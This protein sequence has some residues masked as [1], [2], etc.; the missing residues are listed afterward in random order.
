MDL[1]QA[2]ERVARL[3]EELRR[4]NYLYYSKGEPEIS[5]AEYDRLLAELQELEQRFPR[6]RLPD[7]PTQTVGAPLQTSFTPVRHR[8]P[9]LSLESG[10]SEEAARDF[11]RRLDQA[12]FSQARL[13]AQPKIDGLSVELVYEQGLFHTGST[14]GDGVTGEDITPNLRTIKQIPQHLGPEAPEL[15]VVRG[16]VYMDRSGFDRL[17]RGLLEQGQDA[18]ANPRNAAAGSLRQLNPQVTA[19]RPLRFF[20]FE[21]VNADDLGYQA[22]GQALEALTDLGFPV[23]AEHVRFGQGFDFL[24]QVHADY[25]EVRDELAFEIDGVVFKIDSLEQRALWGVRSRNPR[26]AFAWKFPPREEVTTVREVIVQVGRTGKLTPVAL[27]MPVD[28]SGVTV[29]RATLHNF[30]QVAKLGVRPGDLVRVQRAGDVIP[31]VVS[32]EKEGEPRG[33]EVKPPL[34]CPVCGAG[35]VAADKVVQVTKAGVVKKQGANHLCPNSLGCPA[36]IKG[37]LFHYGSRTAMDIE[38]LGEKSVAQL[39]DKG[40][41]SDLPSLYRLQEKR[42]EMEKLDGWGRLSVDNLLGSIEAT[43]GKSLA[44]FLFALG[45]PGVGEATAREIAEH[46][47]SFEAVAAAGKDT[48]E[49]IPGVG[50][51]VA[52]NLIRFFN[53][54]QTRAVAQALATEVRPKAAVKIRDGE[55]LPL[56]GQTL[57]FTGGMNSL[58]RSEAEALVR[59]LGGRTASSVSAKTGLVVAG[60]NPGT[61]VDKARQLGVKIIS[62]AEFLR[63]AGRG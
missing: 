10:A 59:E 8:R 39:M 12:G 45:I 29:S 58:T 16:E 53:Q 11:L 48:L 1:Q 27:L 26:W 46:L 24:A 20:P 49:A 38:G 50:P 47:G 5:D 6:L 13:V 33:P 55:A 28:V 14:R 61:K 40:F 60:E 4:H 17:N 51:E 42:E 43:R 3:S 36:Q 9:M 44:R 37:A 30:D 54:P 62:E 7:S 32:V 21:L 52:G 15:L 31:Q 23:Q 19:T 57:V 22:D 41:L 2:A 25:Q 18:F 56:A 34:H 35:V 63:L